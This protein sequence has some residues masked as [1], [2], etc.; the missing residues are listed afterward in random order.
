MNII[1]LLNLK[2]TIFI[3]LILL[4]EYLNSDCPKKTLEN[5]CLSECG[6]QYYEF[7]DYCYDN[8]HQQSNL[9]ES[10][11]EEKK[12][13]CDGEN[14]KIFINSTKIGDLNYYRCVDSCYF[15]YYEIRSKICVKKCQESYNKIKLNKGGLGLH[16]CA[17]ECDDNEVLF[18]K[19][20]DNNKMNYCLKKCPEEAKFYYLDGPYNKKIC[21]EKCED[22]NQLFYYETEFGYKCIDTDDCKAPAYIDIESRTFLC[23]EEEEEGVCEDESFPYSF[24]GSCLKNCEDTKKLEF[25]NNKPTY[26]IS[27]Q[28][29]KICSENC[30]EQFETEGKMNKFYKV[31][32]SLYCVDDCKKTDYKFYFGLNCLSSCETTNNIHS[33]HYYDTGEC[34]NS[35]KNGYYLLSEENTCYKDPP[36]HSGKIYLDTS[37]QWNTCENP[38]DP[39]NIKSG[40]GYYINQKDNY[41]CFSSCNSFIIQVTDTIEGDEP[42]T[43]IVDTITYK[44]HKYNNNI[45]LNKDSL[46]SIIGNAFKYQNGDD[47]ILYTSCSDMP[48]N[49]YKYAYSYEKLEASPE[50]ESHFYK[51]IC[52]NTKYSEDDICYQISG[53]FYCY[54]VAGKTESEK[55][56]FCSDASF[57]YLRGKE[58]V[59][60][61]PSEKYKILFETQNGVIKKLGECVDFC[62]YDYPYYSNRD[63]ICYKECSK[64]TLQE[65]IEYTIPTTSIE[66]I[67]PQIYSEGNCLNKCTEDYPYEF[68]DSENKV[69][70]LKNLPGNYYFYSLN[71]VTKI[72]IDDCSKISKYTYGNE[73]VDECVKM[74]NGQSTYKY[75]YISDD[76]KKICV[77]SCKDNENDYQYSLLAKSQHQECLQKCPENY[78]FYYDDKKICLD[79]CGDGGFFDIEEIEKENIKCL[80]SCNGNNKH[81]I[82]GNICS[83]NCTN[84]EPFSIKMSEGIVKCTSNCQNENNNYKYYSINSSGEKYEC[85]I[86]CNY[87][88]FGNQCLKNCPNGL[89]EEL[90]EC[91]SKCTKPYFEKQEIP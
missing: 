83:N 18:T 69:F 88:I 6:N 85:L 78:K 91:K 66:D 41:N 32:N 87:F 36:I 24:E 34:D 27:Y 60:D 70:C 33:L 81:I 38:S 84:E 10:D 19:T 31:P 42:Q 25:F 40:E 29:K 14:N 90:N 50:D 51:Y 47:Y 2:I 82:N 58:C 86:T 1:F 7:G 44:Y 15:G 65:N 30:E 21:I 80:T 75:Y 56:K 9:I 68:T 37:N 12:C 13:M 67:F 4:K 3:L 46:D 57:Y 52:T 53:I 55:A 49:S 43:T 72:C 20:L 16:G 22:N 45:C 73:C 23:S 63:K 74:E 62:T 48:D 39:T 79:Y 35:C 77:D 17:E 54:K 61:C 11:T 8:C 71:N 64:K 76:N 26:F 89:Y 28:G 5:E 59:N